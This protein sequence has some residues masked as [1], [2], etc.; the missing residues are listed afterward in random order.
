MQ[1]TFEPPK[2]TAS[3]EQTTAKRRRSDRVRDHLAN[4]RTYLAWMRSAISLMGFGVVIV[5]IRMFQPPMVPSSGM[6]WKIGLGFAVVGL[7]T[8]W[9][10][11]QHYHGVR[12]DI[13]EDNYEPSDRWVTLFSLAV[14]LLGGGIVYYVFNAPLQAMTSFVFE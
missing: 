12:R 11:T 2:L 1:L 5:R 13:D 10:A 8:V 14:L 4:E 3:S 6:S 7:L 9:L